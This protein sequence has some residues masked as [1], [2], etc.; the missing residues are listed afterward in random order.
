LDPL[1]RV[2]ADMLADGGALLLVQSE[3]SD[4]ARSLEQLRGSGLAARVVLTDRVRFGPVLSEQAGWLEQTGRLEAGRREEKI[5][6]IRA[7][8]PA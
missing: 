6:V 7:D 3:F 8:K 5:A 1:C 4:I 2:A